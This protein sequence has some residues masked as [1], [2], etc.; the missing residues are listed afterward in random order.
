MAPRRS[1]IRSRA[2]SFGAAIYSGTDA[3]SQL[4]AFI[5]FPL[6]GAVLGVMLWLLVHDA[7]LEDTM[8]ANARLGRVRDRVFKGRCNVRRPFSR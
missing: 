6:L 5:I 7:R 3:L 8:L 1:R 4:W 2:R